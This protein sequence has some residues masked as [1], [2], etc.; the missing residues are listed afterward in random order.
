MCIR[1]RI[2]IETDPESDLELINPN[3]FQLYTVKKDCELSSLMEKHKLSYDTGCVYYEFS[4]EE[5][6]ISEDMGVI[7]KDKVKQ[8]VTL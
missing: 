3:H 4:Q 6:D 8:T 1:D 2:L 7:L 5:E